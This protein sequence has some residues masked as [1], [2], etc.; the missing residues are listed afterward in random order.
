M[1]ASIFMVTASGN[2][3]EEAF[4][5]AV[6]DAR[7]ECGYGGYTGTI[8]EKRSFVLVERPRGV[9]PTDYAEEL[10]GEFDKW[11]PAGCIKIKKGKY[12]FFGFASS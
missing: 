6:E 3:A 12:L 8:A 5:S 7:C 11:G 1:G 9:N 4:K 10:V 2:T